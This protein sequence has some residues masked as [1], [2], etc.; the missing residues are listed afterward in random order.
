MPRW[1]NTAGPCNPADHYMLP[2]LRRLPEVRRLIDQKSYFV[3][4]APRQV[5]K[6]T[7][8]LSLARELTTEGRHVAA[9][10]SMEVGAAFPRDVGAAEAAVLESWR[11][12]TRSQLPPELCPPSFPEA[13]PGS[14]IA[15]ALAAWT[16]AA[17]RPLI[18]FLDEIDALRDEVLISV[19]RQLRDGYRNRPE[20]FPLALC[21][22][23]LRD[24]R[25]YK[26]E[27]GDS[28]TLGTASPFNIKVRSL[29]LRNFT[30]EEVAELYAQHTAD[31]RQPFEPEALARAF[32]L[33]QGQ[34]WLVNALAKVAVEEL[35]PNTAQPVRR[36]DIDRAKALL[37]E[38]RETHL[39][40]LAERLRE[41]R[42]RHI[43]EPMLA[44]L[45]LGDVPEDDLRFIQDLG[46]VRMAATGGLEVANPIYR[47]IIPRVLANTAMASLPRLPATWLRAD[48][49]LDIERLME[50]F[51]AFW[52]QHGQPL[53]STAPYHEI[54]PHLVL[55]AFLH[56]VA[57]G[58][59]SLEREYAI[60][61]GRMDVCLR[62]G[63][64]TLAMELKVW[65]DGE[66]DPLDEGLAQLDGYLAGLGLSSGWLII[67]DRRN[68]Q[69]PLAERTHATTAVTRA[70]RRVTVLRA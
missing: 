25:D 65:R 11:N 55:M 45:T 38:R 14:R 43:L 51:M 34:P 53:L 23:G 41:P 70:S 64:D 3:V 40:S 44:G 16:E 63:P 13:P 31:T 2:A 35:V 12:A 20:H 21:L 4:H 30:A 59:G 17:P 27:V 19:L 50:A 62:H 60:G 56:R 10:V 18:V 28:D 58:G 61:T 24:V 52:R 33:T 22:I 37:I 54:A 48:G 8:L 29:T 36:A 15:A 39:D 5:G 49:R 68:G 6:T 1:F 9:L 69:P 32:E 47:E 46:L 67:F 42:V 57:N 7:A 66:K 26:V